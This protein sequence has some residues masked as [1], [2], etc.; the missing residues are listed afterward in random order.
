[1]WKQSEFGSEPFFLMILSDVFE[2][3]LAVCIF[4]CF[5]NINIEPQDKGIAPCVYISVLYL[6]VEVK[7]GYREVILFYYYS[8]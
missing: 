4:S 2:G 5:T 6:W 3:G 1:M 8:K 7:E